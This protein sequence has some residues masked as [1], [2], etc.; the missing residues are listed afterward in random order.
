MTT[1]RSMWLPL[2]RR[3]SFASKRP[4]KR[5][6]TARDDDLSSFFLTKPKTEK[7]DLENRYLN[8]LEIGHAAMQGL[9]VSMEDKHIIDPL[10]TLPDHVMVAVFDGKPCLASLSLHFTHSLLPYPTMPCHGLLLCLCLPGHC[11]ILVAEHAAQHLIPT[12]ESTSQWKAY[13]ALSATQRQSQ[14]G[15]DLVEQALVQAF[16]DLDRALRAVLVK[17]DGE[18]IEVINEAGCA[19]VCSLITPTHIFCANLGDSRC[20]L[21]TT[22]QVVALSEDHKPELPLEMERIEKAGGFVAWNR[23]NGMLAMS[24]ALGDFT[25]KISSHAKTDK[26]HLVI[27]Y[28]DIA[29]RRRDPKEDE[30]LVVAC[31]GVWDV[32]KNEHAVSFVSG[33]V[34]NAKETAAKA[35]SDSNGQESKGYAQAAA[36]ALID[37]ALEME[38]S[39]NISAVVVCFPALFQ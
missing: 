13:L 11:G 28:P 30:V 10:T 26:D 22:S 16:V 37:F 2:H 4:A 3:P 6:A 39:D 14:A 23:V 5:Q 20:I 25:Y 1:T 35:N 19:A 34:R 12:L 29:V 15:V 36:V 9:R 24:R 33:H 31:D 17:E 27:A 38:S 18:E 21:G 32:L 7:L 8:G